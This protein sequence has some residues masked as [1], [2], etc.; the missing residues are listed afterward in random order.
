MFKYRLEYKPYRD[1][2]TSNTII[3]A[4]Q[5]DVLSF[6]INNKDVLDELS[7][8]SSIIKIERL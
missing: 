6:V 4:T 7:F 8:Y 5:L 2:R 3:E 1:K